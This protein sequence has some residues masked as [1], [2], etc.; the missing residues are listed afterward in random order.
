[1]TFPRFE[2][3][4]YRVED[5]LEVIKNALTWTETKHLLYMNKQTMR[6]PYGHSVSDYDLPQNANYRLLTENVELMASAFFEIFEK[7]FD[8]MIDL[9][10][11]NGVNLTRDQ[12]GDAMEQTVLVL[13]NIDDSFYYGKASINTIF[14]VLSKLVQD[15]VGFSYEIPIMKLYSQEI[16]DRVLNGTY[17]KATMFETNKMYLDHIS[18][19]I[20]ANRD[21]ILEAMPDDEWIYQLNYLIAQRMR[22]RTLLASDDCTKINR[23]SRNQAELKKYSTLSKDQSATVKKIHKDLRKYANDI[24]W[25]NI[26]NLN[27]SHRLVELIE[28]FGSAKIQT[29]LKKVKERFAVDDIPCPITLSSSTSSCYYNSFAKEAKRLYGQSNP[30]K[31]I[32]DIMLSENWL[33]DVDFKKSND[34]YFSFL[35]ISGTNE[36]SSEDVIL[37]LGKEFE[38]KD[39]VATLDE[40]FYS[41]IEA[42]SDYLILDKKHTNEDKA[43]LAATCVWLNYLAACLIENS[44]GAL[45]DGYFN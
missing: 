7:H 15:I 20:R 41:K 2:E 39:H 44:F 10:I 13:D 3:T 1:M 16:I 26:A 22:D 42:V 17:V 29:A 5:V 21:K 33:E 37:C 40:L 4:S 25:S 38:M 8:A 9:C 45:P 31:K 27:S 12:I 32:E 14:K 35:S 6:L 19:I 34:M 30:D 23:L 36:E 43:M 28:K 24:L 11:S 18:D